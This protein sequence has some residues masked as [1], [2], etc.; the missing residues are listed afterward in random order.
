[1]SGNLSHLNKLA[2]AL[3][4]LKVS[5]KP[6]CLVVGGW[7]RD[8]LLG[9]EPT[10][11]DLEV[12]GV[13]QST[14]DK[15][16][17]KTF[18]K[19][20]ITQSKKFGTWTILFKP[21]IVPTLSFR[22]S[23]REPESILKPGSRL[24]GRDDKTGGLIAHIGKIQNYV[25]N[26]SLPRAETKTGKGYFGFS[27]QLN[28]SLSIKQA[29]S[30]RDFT[31]NALYLD[32]LTNAVIDPCD[33]L[34]DINSKTLRAV[35]PGTFSEDPLRLYRAIQLVAR[36][37]LKAEPKTLYLLKKMAKSPEIK[38]L[39]E[40]RVKSVLDKMY[41]KGSKPELGMLLAQKLNLS[42]PSTW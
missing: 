17:R 35:N 22:P 27:I 33:G 4:L 40:K 39:S 28:P 29:A 19:T 32:P 5:P 10:D 42:L 20:S 8:E 15:I 34:K 31:I 1:M 38:T 7:V 30:R 11:V 24:V 12:F 41:D 2:K 9:I 14:L 13:S 18:P 16:I 6:R 23:L 36:F 37:S 3:Q 26:V 21:D 25:I